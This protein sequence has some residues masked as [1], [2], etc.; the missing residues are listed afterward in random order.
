MKKEIK[1]IKKAAE[2]IKKAI[3]KKER[4]IIYGDADMDGASSVIILKE[5]IMSLGRPADSGSPVSAVYFPDRETEG[6]GINKDALNY[7][8][9]YAPALFIT[10]DLGIGNFEE[11]KLAKRLGFEVMI[12]DHHEVL[13]KLPSASIIVNP[14]R[15]DDKYPFKEFAAAGVVFKLAEALMDKKMTPVLRNN[16][17]ELAGLAT[18]ADMMIEEE[19]NI[20]IITMGL[21]SLKNTFRPGLKVFAKEQGNTSRSVAQKIISAC[22]AAGTLENHHNEAYVLLTSTSMEEAEHLAEELIEKSYIRQQKIRE[23]TEEVEKRIL[24]K[25]GDSIIFEG[26]K[27]WPILMAGPA[28]SRICNL[29]KKPVFL[30]S[31]REKDSQGAVRTPKGIDGVKP[32]IHCS[33]YLDTY[34]GHPQAAG[35]RVKNEHLENFK[36]CLIEYFRK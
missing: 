5:C 21:A 27:D 8:K 18:V 31:Q 29:Y 6:Y 12:V 11:V 14:K 2:R 32:M 16:F 13:K 33:K 23:I 17:L 4:I 19:D 20:E 15:K 10:V 3:K 30:Y 34:G 24:R 1:N 9:K 35:F 7:L 36:K 25:T 26:D 22:H 28:S